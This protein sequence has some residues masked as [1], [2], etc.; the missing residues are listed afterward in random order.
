MELRHITVRFAEKTVLEDFSLVLPDRG[1]LC[2]SGPSGCGKTTL[3]RVLC[4]L[5]RPQAG[6]VLDIPKTA[7]VFQEDRLLPWL[8]VERNLTAVGIPQ[9]QAALWLQRVGLGAEKKSLPRQLSGGMRRRVAIARALGVDSGLLL[10][11]EPFTGLD[12]ETRKQIYPWL[13][14]ASEQKPVVLVTHHREEA[15]ALGAT[16]LELTGPPLRLVQE[17]FLC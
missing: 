13:R 3:L 9:D 17:E 8:T 14:Q 2:L 15:E 5:E 11:D 6:R 10:L 16:V 7:V 12:E 1:V 4:G